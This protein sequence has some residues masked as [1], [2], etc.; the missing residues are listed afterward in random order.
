MADSGS[1]GA[2]T[3]TPPEVSDNMTTPATPGAP[4][5]RRFEIRF[6]VPSDAPHN[7][8]IE[9]QDTTG[10]NI[11]YDQ[12]R[13]PGDIVDDNV[14]GFGNKIIFRIFIDGKLIRQDT[15]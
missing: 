6:K 7:C 1:G 4:K 3:S 10:T 13:D 11:V 8:Q 9:V 2:D 5:Q 12:D 15:K 14:I